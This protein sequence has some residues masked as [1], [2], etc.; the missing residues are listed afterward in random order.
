MKSVLFVCMANICR[1]PVLEATL[2]HMAVQRGKELY[3][4]SCGVGWVHLGE[5][6]DPRSFAAASSKGI[7]VDHHAQQ[8]QNHFFEVFDHIFAVDDTILEQ[9]KLQAAPEHHAKIEL[10]T[11]YSKKY[12]GR[13]IPDPYYHSEDGFTVVMEMILDSCE[14]IL[15]LL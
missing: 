7:V 15:P 8:L 10:A 12:K 2:R 6:P 5:R 9:L 1:S 13:E 11:A 4:D 14:G 3:V